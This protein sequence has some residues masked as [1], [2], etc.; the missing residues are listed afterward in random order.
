MIIVAKRMAAQLFVC[1]IAQ[2]PH[3]RGNK[4]LRSSTSEWK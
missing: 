4:L 3:R 1:N 2:F